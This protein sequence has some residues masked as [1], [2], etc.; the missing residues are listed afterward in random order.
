MGNSYRYS[1]TRQ[2]LESQISALFVGRLAEEI[3][4][5]SE[6]VTTGA[7]NDI[8]RATEIAR[9]MVTKWGLSAKLGPLTFGEDDGEVFL[10]HSVT[11]RKE[12]SEDTAN[13]IDVEVH[14]IIDRNYQRAEQLLKD[15]LDKLHAM[16]EALIKYETIDED[17]IDDIMDGKIPGPPSGWSDE[18]DA[19]NTSGK[20]D[21]IQKRKGNDTKIGDPA[22]D[23]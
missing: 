5:G 8:Q 13:T 7:S 2:R 16:A 6:K 23:H 20:D 11:K 3:I 9:N 4:F 18:D 12:F 21:T 14:S 15:N 17:Q 19:S 22:T 10:G 1:L